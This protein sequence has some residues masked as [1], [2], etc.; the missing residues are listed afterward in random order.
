M[1]RLT[2]TLD[3]SIPKDSTV[4]DLTGIDH[5]DLVSVRHTPWALW[6]TRDEVCVSVRVSVRARY[7]KQ[8]QRV[9]HSTLALDASVRRR[10]MLY[11]S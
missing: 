1:S 10:G 11:S 6:V 5:N 2:S 4:R 9:L 8:P 7:A 3:S